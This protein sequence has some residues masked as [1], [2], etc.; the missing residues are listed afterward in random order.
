MTLT[1]YSGGEEKRR[2]IFRE[3]EYLFFWRRRKTEKEKG[4]NIWRKSLKKLSRIL[5][6]LGLGLET[7][8]N[9]CRVS[10]SVLKDFGLGKKVSV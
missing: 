10:V 5:R 1:F 8:V 6:S 7:F 2:L 3:E 9:F 4:E